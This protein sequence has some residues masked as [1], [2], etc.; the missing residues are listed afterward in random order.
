MLYKAKKVISERHVGR[1]RFRKFL[2]PRALAERPVKKE[3][4][5]RLSWRLSIFGQTG[6]TTHLPANRPQ[7]I[8][9][10]I[11]PLTT[12]NGLSQVDSDRCI[13]EQGPAP[14]TYH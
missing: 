13:E 4:L 2:G 12:S 1:S 3:C 14:P 11:K 8:F 5:W 9:T 10:G 6:S 7:P